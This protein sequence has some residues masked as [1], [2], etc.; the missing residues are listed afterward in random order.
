MARVY[1]YLY[2]PA[3]TVE[4]R[5]LC[6]LAYKPETKRGLAT[7]ARK[8][9][10]YREDRVSLEARP[11]TA[12]LRNAALFAGAHEGYAFA[13]SEKGRWPLLSRASSTP[14]AGIAVCA[15]GA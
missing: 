4:K 9:A 13:G 10:L 14:P 8:R 7:L 2:C 1:I 6:A 11:T 12:A 5:I 3:G 15:A